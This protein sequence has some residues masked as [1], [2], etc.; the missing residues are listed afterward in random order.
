MIYQNVSSN[1]HCSMALCIET[2][3]DESCSID[4]F[5]LSVLLERIL[6]KKPCLKVLRF[7]ISLINIIITYVVKSCSCVSQ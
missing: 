7:E 2:L 6:E 5:I 1:T 3:L 4:V